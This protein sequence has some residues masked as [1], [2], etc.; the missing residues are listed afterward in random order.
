MSGFPPKTDKELTLRLS[1]HQVSNPNKSILLRC[2]WGFGKRQSNYWLRQ[3]VL[4]AKEMPGTPVKLL[5]TREECMTQSIYHPVTKARL[6]AG[7]DENGDITGLKIRISGQSISVFSLKFLI[8]DD[9]SDPLVFQALAPEGDFQ[10]SY[11]FPALRID[12]A[13][14][15][16]FVRPA[17]WRGV[18]SN[19]NTIYMESFMDELAAETGKDPLSSEES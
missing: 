11:G 5:Y 14:R 1:R 7:L 6:E 4:I 16:T 12:H 15:N 10:I 8:Q 19:Q 13:M 17:V 9:G 2:I 3:A 18:N